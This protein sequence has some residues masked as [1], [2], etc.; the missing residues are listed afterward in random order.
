MSVSETQKRR[1]KASENLQDLAEE[2]KYKSKMSSNTVLGKLGK[3]TV[4]KLVLLV[5]AFVVILKLWQLMLSQST[6]HTTFEPPE[7]KVELPKWRYEYNKQGTSKEHLQRVI[8]T[9]E[10]G[11]EWWFERPVG[12]DELNRKANATKKPLPKVENYYKSTSSLQF[13]ER[14]FYLDGKPFR[15]LSGAM[16]YFRVMPEHW[17]DRMEKM[18]SCGLNT[19]ETYVCHKLVKSVGHHTA[20]FRFKSCCQGSGSFKLNRPTRLAGIKNSTR[21]LVILSRIG[22]RTCK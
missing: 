2:D 15:I 16:H 10:S 14:Q 12:Q 8:Q 11:G 13:R 18:K 19:L 3:L 7:V 6:E 4:K 5:I 1:N 17:E 21:L 20:I 22:C 9:L